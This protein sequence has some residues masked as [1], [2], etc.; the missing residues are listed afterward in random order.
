ML[1]NGV[2]LKVISEALGNISV[3]FT[4]DVYSH[5]IRGLQ[6]DAM[7]L[8]DEVLPAAQNGI[9]RKNNANLT[10]THSIMSSIN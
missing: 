5:I 8:L 3:A 6:S 1:L 2:P 7:E 9:H 10:P 4:I